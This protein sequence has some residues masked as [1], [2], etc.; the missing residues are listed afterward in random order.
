M[1]FLYGL[2]DLALQ[3]L[4]KPGQTLP[5]PRMAVRPSIK[6]ILDNLIQVRAEMIFFTE[7]TLLKYSVQGSA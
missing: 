5:Q 6:F 2:P 1:M 4:L 3:R 7:F